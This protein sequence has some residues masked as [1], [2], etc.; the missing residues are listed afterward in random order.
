MIDAK[1]FKDELSA[2]LDQLYETR[3][4]ILKRQRNVSLNASPRAVLSMSLVPAT[5]SV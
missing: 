1:R 4:K 3:M 2:L 5:P